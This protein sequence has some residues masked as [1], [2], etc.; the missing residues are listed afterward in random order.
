MQETLADPSNP[1]RMRQ[2]SKLSTPHPPPPPS[3]KHTRPHPTNTTFPQRYPDGTPGLD[4]F[5]SLA[6][7]WGAAPTYVLPAYA[8]GVRAKAAGFATWELRVS[9][10][11]AVGLTEAEGRVGTAFGVLEVRWRKVGDSGEEGGIEVVVEVKAPRGTRGRV[12]GCSE[13]VVGDGGRVVRRVRV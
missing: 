13:E 3:P 2:T 5:T 4:L 1:F 10:G 11:L 6:H 9:A 7:P 8:L 12:V